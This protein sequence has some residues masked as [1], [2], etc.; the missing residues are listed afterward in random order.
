VLPERQFHNPIAKAIIEARKELTVHPEDRGAVAETLSDLSLRPGLFGDDVVVFMSLRTAQARLAVNHD[1]DTIPAVQQQMW[2]T[3]LRIED[4]RTTTSQSDLRQAM[5]KLQDALARNAPDAEVS[6]LMQELQQAIDRYLQALAQQ[7]R[8]QPQDQQQMQP[9]DPSHMLTRQDLQRM[10]DRAGDLARTGSRE[11]AQNLLSQ[12][13]QMLENL[14]MAQPGQMQSGQNQAMRQM[15]D[16]M[17][18]QQQLLDRSFRRSQQ[19][20][21]G[22]QQGRQQQGGDENQGDANEQEMLRQMLGDMMQQLGDQGGDMPAPMAQANRAMRDAVQALRRAQPGQATGPQTQA[23]D[24]LQQAARA[25]AQQMMGRNGNPDGTEQGDNE[26]LEQAKRDPFGRLTDENGNGGLD[27]GGLMRT[28]KSPNDYAL[29]QAK[30]IL[31]EL[32]Q[33]DGERDRPALEHDYIDR[34]LKQF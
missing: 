6:R 20:Q 31:E 17:R 5:Q 10:L 26:G 2:E 9:V 19:Q 21:G 13:Q 22:Q 24:A 27:D 23:L 15:Q 28:G 34:L 18:R 7:M 33:R 25:M 14:R 12:L 4:G 30:R 32:R 29:E 11:A 16:M 3:A 8:N 1:P